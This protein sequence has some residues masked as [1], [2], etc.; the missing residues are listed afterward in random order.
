[1]RTRRLLFLGAAAV[2]VPLL[3]SPAAPAKKAAVTINVTLTD[4]AIK[5][6]K[7][8]APAGKVTFNVKNTGKAKHSFKITNK[9]T[10]ALATGKTAKLV[11]TFA[12]A[13]K[14]PY[15]STQPGD[16]AKGLKGSFTVT[17]APGGGANLAAGK[18]VFSLT[19][20]G[21]CHVFAAGGGV[22]T[23]GPNLDASKMS[24]A[25]IVGI[26]TKGKGTMPPQ[27][28]ILSTQQIQ[29]VANF[30]FSSRAG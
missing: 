3:L 13:G 20:C 10:A 29:D 24:V 8:T 5:L 19:G 15:Q 22:G 11:I 26:V 17:K 14:F 23:V 16:V 1:M 12:K 27:A 6:S 2:A 4:S 7:K 28:G 9:K 18:T 21:T 30:V 25:G